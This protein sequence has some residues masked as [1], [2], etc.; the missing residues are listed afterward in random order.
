MGEY[1]DMK[2]KEN[3]SILEES[4]YGKGRTAQ[5][6]GEEEREKIVRAAERYLRWGV[7]YKIAGSETKG[8][9]QIYNKVREKWGIENEGEETRENNYWAEEEFPEGNAIAYVKGGI[10]TPR[11]FWKKLGVSYEQEKGKFFWLRDY[12]KV[13]TGETYTAGRN[14]DSAKAPVPAR[15]LR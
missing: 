14:D 11:T 6:I 12:T 1:I 15:R 13:D 3:R 10:D 5:A 8:E 7:E 4:L 2:E 9:K